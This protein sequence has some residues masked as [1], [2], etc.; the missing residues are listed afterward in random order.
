MEDLTQAIEL[1]ASIARLVRAGLS[2]IQTIKL[3]L[4][5]LANPTDDKHRLAVADR[6]VARAV[7][8][9]LC[10]LTAIG[11]AGVVAREALKPFALTRGEAPNTS[12][13]PEPSAGHVL[14]RLR[15]R[16]SPR[17]SAYG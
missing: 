10:W 11:Y 9:F 12:P 6:L 4:D 3:L 16:R 14:C 13:P 7:R 15:W 5:S 17:P 1:M 8:A 2:L